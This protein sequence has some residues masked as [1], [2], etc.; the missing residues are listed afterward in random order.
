[1]KIFY[2][3]ETKTVWPKRS[4]LVITIHIKCPACVDK[5]SEK[6]FQEIQV[7]FKTKYVQN[8]VQEVRLHL[9]TGMSLTVWCNFSEDG[10]SES[11]L[12]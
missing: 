4:T 8:T 11:T 2:F 7:S 10:T 6:I 9:T 3:N 5:L 12:V 1:M